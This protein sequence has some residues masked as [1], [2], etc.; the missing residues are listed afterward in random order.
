M[1]ENSISQ[2]PL[3]R[4]MLVSALP[5]DPVPVA[6]EPKRLWAP[7]WLALIFGVVSGTALTL[8]RAHKEMAVPGA[9]ALAGLILL[10]GLA[11]ILRRKRHVEALDPPVTVAY[12]VWML[13]VIFLAG[14]VQI[15]FL[16][17]NPQE[18]VVKAL[19]LSVGLSLAAYCVD[20]SLFARFAK[21]TVD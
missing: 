9:F 12:V 4:T 16:P 5:E 20:R 14:P 18:I 19:V 15:L 13:V 11:T 3:L 21:P 7:W 2:P 8:L 10:V 1:S 6:F 17:S